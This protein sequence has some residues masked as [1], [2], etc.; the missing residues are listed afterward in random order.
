MVFLWH[1]CGV[2]VALLMSLTALLMELLTALL[3]VVNGVV[4]AVKCC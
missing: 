1:C 3:M 2:V 4:E